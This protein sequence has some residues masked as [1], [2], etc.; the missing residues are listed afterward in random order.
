MCRVAIIFDIIG[1]LMKY[2]YCFDICP[3]YFHHDRVEH[4]IVDD[5]VHGD[6]DRVPGE[7]LLGRDVK[8]DCPQVNLLVVINAGEDK[9]YSRAF[10]S[11]ISQPSETENN[12]SFILLYDLLISCRRTGEGVIIIYSVPDFTLMQRHSDRG[13]VSSTSTSEARDR[14]RAQQPGPV[15]SAEK[16]TGNCVGVKRT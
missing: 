6:C 3:S 2:F 7:N 13:A 12:G 5:G 11:T 10:C 4:P 1:R 16:F 9:K 8:A 15:V 14:S